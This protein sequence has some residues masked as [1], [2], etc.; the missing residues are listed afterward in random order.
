M[1]LARLYS[2]GLREE[3]LLVGHNFE[4]EAFLGQVVLED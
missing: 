2:G 3:H 1:P 4:R